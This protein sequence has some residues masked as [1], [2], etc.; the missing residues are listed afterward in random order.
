MHAQ[1]HQIGTRIDG[2]FSALWEAGGTDLLLT[3]GMPPLLRVHGDLA[4]GS[5][6]PPC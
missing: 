1:V 2:L 3:V 5:G 4:P 6:R